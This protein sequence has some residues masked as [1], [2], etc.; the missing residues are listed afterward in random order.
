MARGMARLSSRPHLERPH[1]SSPHFS[2]SETWGQFRTPER[3][4]WE[5]SPGLN[6]GMGAITGVV[7][8]AQGRHENASY[9][10]RK[11]PVSQRCRVRCCQVAEFH[12]SSCV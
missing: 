5:L 11:L 8:R 2:S 6:D 4:G 1:L 12:R 7:P 3:G 9:C 10:H